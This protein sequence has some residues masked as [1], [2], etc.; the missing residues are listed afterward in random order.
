MDKKRQ[1]EN[2]LLRYKL[3]KTSTDSAIR[4]IL[5]L[6][7]VSGSCSTCLF[8]KNGKQSCNRFTSSAEFKPNG[9]LIGTHCGNDN[10]WKHYIPYRNYR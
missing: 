8:S 3:V 9:K 4:D 6:F 5:H 2:I 7:S 1:L 10:N